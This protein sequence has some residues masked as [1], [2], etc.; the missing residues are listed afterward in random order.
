MP[1]HRRGL[2]AVASLALLAGC[3]GASQLSPAP[4]GAQSAAQS[5][6]RPS[7]AQG[8]KHPLGAFALSAAKLAAL[9]NSG[10]KVPH[11]VV[12]NR[13]RSK[14]GPALFVSDYV[15]NVVQE[16]Q[17]ER[18]GGIVATIS[19]VVGPQGMDTDRH[20][21]L[22]VTSQGTSAVNVYAPGTYTASKVLNEGNQQAPAS[23]A[24]CPDSSVYVSN[25]YADYGY[26]NGSIQI[27][28]PGATTPTGSIPDSNIYF[29]FFVSCD[30][31]GNV[32]YD[33]L[34]TNFVT[35][36]AE[37]VPSTGT[38]TEFGSLGIGFPG[39][40]RAFGKGLLSIDDQSVNQAS[41][42][43]QV[44]QASNI[45]AG[46]IARISGFADPV[47]G[48]WGRSDTA[49]WQAD[50]T[51]QRVEYAKLLGS[52]QIKYFIGAGVL[53][54]PEDALVFPVGNR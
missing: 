8:M 53:Q 14:W 30:R 17:P 54:G 9:R 37:Y 38:I 41:G 39:G 45:V 26:Q 31:T 10:V 4:I 2:V 48:S 40:I 18:A 24:V 33:Y 44:F 11:V 32:W 12:P 46:P 7:L 21:N 23:V 20:D 49:T 13:R 36:V 6:G 51:N 16:F 43:V 29:S 25:T 19:D 22:Y 52:P 47:S 28:A 3:S 5:T 1:Q 15:G 42:S 27:F 34:D 35:G 50:I